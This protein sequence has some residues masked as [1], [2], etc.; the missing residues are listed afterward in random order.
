MT[1]H[2]PYLD[3]WRGLAIVSLLVGHFFPVNG[4]N[5][6]T[7]GV[8]LFFVLSGL[9]MAR[10]LFIQ[11]T[12]L[13]PFYQR[14]ISRV[15]PSV[16]VYVL[17]IALCFVIAGRQ[18]PLAELLPAITFTNNY[19]MP[20]K[21]S[22]P[23]GHIWSLSVEEH[24][25]LILSA[26]AYWCRA[27]GG[28]ELAALVYVLCASV[29]AI[30]IYSCLP[31]AEAMR[32]HLRTEVASFGIFASAAVLLKLSETEF[33]PS[34]QG[35]APVAL[36]IGILAHWW[37]VPVAARI[38]FGW[39]A[40]AVAINAMPTAPQAVLAIFGSSWLR[41]LGTYSFSI[42]LWQQP[43]YLF[44]RHEGMSPWLGLALAMLTGVVAYYLVER[45]ARRYLNQR[46]TT[47][48]ASPRSEDPVEVPESRITVRPCVAR[49]KGPLVTPAP[50]RHLNRHIVCSRRPSRFPLPDDRQ[51]N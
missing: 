46:W 49:N 43:Y 48:K 18:V 6:G 5:L 41:Q 44:V 1:K 37:S 16:A 50:R 22:M 14:R 21:S 9:L 47:S 19:I 23:F 15:L 42:Y 3:G 4:I 40:L 39:S 51:Q 2:I 10:V 7:V 17:V 29:A 27:R 28:R 20:Q 11:N 36:L 24:S 34:F 8:A 13:I 35:L 32:F 26:V 45:P 31:N 33:Q 38:I 25:Y 30:L 12:P